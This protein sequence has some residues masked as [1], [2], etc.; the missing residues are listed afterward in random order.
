MIATVKY[1]I[2]LLRVE[3]D[4]ADGVCRR[5]N[6]ITTT[7]AAMP[8]HSAPRATVVDQWRAADIRV[9]RMTSVSTTR[10]LDG[11]DAGGGRW[12]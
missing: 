3:T 7:A 12:R 5:K 11:P 10:H 4:H 2:R 9:R 8:Q 1:W 6:M